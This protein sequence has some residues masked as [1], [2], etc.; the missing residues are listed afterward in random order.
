MQAP[1]P[2]KSIGC[3]G[4]CTSGITVEELDYITDNI[5]NT[6][7]H[8]KGRLIFK[9]YIERYNLQSSLECLELYEVCCE[10]LT[11]DLTRS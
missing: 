3:I 5:N 10:F 9:K 11:K 8:P 4:K 2:S 6:L 1:S 7:S